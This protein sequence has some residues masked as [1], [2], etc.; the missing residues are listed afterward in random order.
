MLKKRILTGVIGIAVV[1][2]V[3]TLC[4]YLYSSFISRSGFTFDIGS[5]LIAPLAVGIVMFF[6]LI[7]MYNKD[8]EKSRVKYEG[9]HE[10]R[11]HKAGE[12]R[13]K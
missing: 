12:E 6:V 8:M 9:L 2:G 11:H 5:N 10:K 13:K 7:P 1:F 3:W 4:D